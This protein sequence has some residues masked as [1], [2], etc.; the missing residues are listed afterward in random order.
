MEKSNKK[1]H[2]NNSKQ[3]QDL[4]HLFINELKD[5][6]WAEKA[7]LKAI[8]VMV[9]NAT[10]PELVK[11]LTNHTKQTQEHVIRL[12]NV[13]SI[14]GEKPEAK[15]CEA[16][17]GLIKE[18]EEIMHKTV[19]GVVR[20]AGI[21]LAGQKVE[22]YEIATYGTLSAFAKSIDEDEVVAILRK[23]LSDEKQADIMLSEIAEKFINLDAADVNDEGSIEND[24][25]I[26]IEHSDI[27]SKYSKETHNAIGEHYDNNNNFDSFKGAI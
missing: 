10:T 1:V 4:R 22:H 7:L 25:A 12:E 23:T 27:N 14:M 9:E 20:D 2:S 26:K 13:F 18:A 24:K 11:A 15:K 16:M 17:D 19:K 6:Y 5:I 21:I 3:A 8:P